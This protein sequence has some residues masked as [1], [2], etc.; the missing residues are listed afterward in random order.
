MVKA[1]GHA[2]KHPTYRLTEK[3]VK[4]GINS[5]IEL[6]YS[7]QSLVKG[8]GK[9]GKA[10]RASWKKWCLCWAFCQ[11]NGYPRGTGGPEQGSG[12]RKALC[13]FMGA[14]AWHLH[15]EAEGDGAGK[16]GRMGQ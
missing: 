11:R 3:C 15:Q 10:E 14:C 5:E 8:R 7:R 13:G 1:I 4:A 6:Q 2:Q 9:K 12:E 16:A